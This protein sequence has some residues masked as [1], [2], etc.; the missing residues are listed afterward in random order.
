MK[1]T[2]KQGGI[3]D[4]KADAVIVNLFEGVKNPGGG[5]G[6]MDKALGGKISALIKRFDFDGGLADNICAEKDG[7]YV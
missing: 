1:V 2:V 5:T 4:V 3:A 6:A 7:G